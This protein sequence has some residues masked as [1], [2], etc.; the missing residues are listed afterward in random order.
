MTMQLMTL[1]IHDTK[2]G[3][4]LYG[5]ARPA[6]TGTRLAIPLIKT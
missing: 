2:F 6:W 5:I 3:G 1:H 4:W